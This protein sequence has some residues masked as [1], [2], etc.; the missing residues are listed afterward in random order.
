MKSFL[1][2]FS[3]YCGFKKGSCQLLAKVCAQ[4]LINHLKDKP[5]EEKYEYHIYHMCLDRLV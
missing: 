2:S 3:F 5:A 4:V 1:G